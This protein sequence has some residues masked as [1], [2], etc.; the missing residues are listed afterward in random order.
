MTG[1]SYVR[2]RDSFTLKH[3]TFEVLPSSE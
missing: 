2:T 3:D 1:N